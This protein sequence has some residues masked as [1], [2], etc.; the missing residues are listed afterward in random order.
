LPCWTERNASMLPAY[1][2]SHRWSSW[3]PVGNTGRPGRRRRRPSQARP[4]S[5]ATTS[6][7]DRALPSSA[8]QARCWSRPTTT[9]R[10]PLLSDYAVCS[11]WSR[12]TIT[13]KNDG[14]CSE[15]LGHATVQITLDTYSHVL[16]GLDAQAAET[17]ARLIMGDGAASTDVSKA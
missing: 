13:V 15:R 2:P 11:A 8:V 5:S 1:R 16:P 14:S 4:S 7:T 3:L 10:L 12:Q 6:T 17:V 9:T